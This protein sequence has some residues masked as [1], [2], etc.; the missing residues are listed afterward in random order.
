MSEAKQRTYR[1]TLVRH[2][3]E[4]RAWWL[5]EMADTA[6]PLSE[7]MTLFWHN[8]FVSAQPNGLLAAG[9]VSPER[10]L[11]REHAAGSFAALVAATSRRGQP[12]ENLAR[13]LM[14]SFT[15]LDR[16]G[17]LPHQIDFRALYATVPEQ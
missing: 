9:A 3:L 5:R 13:E 12:N 16:T 17:N 14:E 6:S 1:Q 4:L 15:L 10:V 2:S 8:H 11:L 7:R